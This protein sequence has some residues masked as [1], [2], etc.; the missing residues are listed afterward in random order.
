MTESGD[1]LLM[2]LTVSGK[3]PLIA[4]QS[5]AAEITIITNEILVETIETV[6]VRT[7]VGRFPT[8]DE[9][10]LFF[11]RPIEVAGGLAIAQKLYAGYGEGAP[12]GQ[13]PDQDLITSQGNTYLK[14]NFP[15][16]DYIQSATLQ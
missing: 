2:P 1:R 14:A 5:L 7:I 3:N 8:G 16:L 12:D 11:I 4:E 9:H 10:P 15:L 6:E 13:G